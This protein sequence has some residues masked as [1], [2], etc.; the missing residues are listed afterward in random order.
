MRLQSQKSVD[1]RS[2]NGD[3]AVLNMPSEDVDTVILHVDEELGLLEI[4][5]ELVL[6][7]GQ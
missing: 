3:L 5:V 4:E 2:R 6:S 1:L 7:Q